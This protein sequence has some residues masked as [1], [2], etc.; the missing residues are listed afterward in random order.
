MAMSSKLVEEKH[1]VNFNNIT[2]SQSRF[3]AWKKSMDELVGS[4]YKNSRQPSP[5]EIMAVLND[6]LDELSSL[7]A[8]VGETGLEL[9]DFEGIL[10]Q[11]RSTLETSDDTKQAGL[12]VSTS[13]M[14]LIDIF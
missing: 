1:E 6:K 2:G 10:I 13:T 8:A 11:I 7:I 12:N 3:A 4:F 5:D 14:L 9:P